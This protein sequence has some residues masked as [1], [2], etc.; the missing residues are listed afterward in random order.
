MPE[1]DDLFEEQDRELSGI[2]R[3]L[4]A[5]REQGEAKR[6]YRFRQKCN[7]EYFRQHKRVR[8]VVALAGW[9][10]SKN[11][12]GVGRL[13][14]SLT[15]LYAVVL[16]TVWLVLGGVPHATGLQPHLGILSALLF[17]LSTTVNLSTGYFA[18]GGWI[19]NL[20][21]AIQGISAYFALGYIL[22]VAQRSYEG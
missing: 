3:R 7:R 19:S 15:V 12:S 18:P 17:S 5:V 11:G 10:A 6:L 1:S 16:P 20:F 4:A 21:Q 13:V 22:W 8:Y 14:L 2:Q 9:I